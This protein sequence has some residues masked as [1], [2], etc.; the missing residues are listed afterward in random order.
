[1]QLRKYKVVTNLS[2]ERKTPF[3][4]YFFTFVTNETRMIN[5]LS[6]TRMNNPDSLQ[7]MRVTSN[8]AEIFNFNMMKEVF[9]VFV[10]ILLYACD[11]PGR[12]ENTVNGRT[13]LLH[14]IVPFTS[15]SLVN[16]VIEIPAGTNQKWEVNKTTGRI[17]WEQITPDSFRV[18]N[19]LP[20]PANYGF[21]PQTLLPEA[22]GGDGDP[23]DVFVLGSSIAREKI[24][25][26]RIIGIIHMLDDNESDSKL[27]AVNI[28]DS[29]F[30][31]H[32]Y[33]MLIEEYPGVIDI[34]KLWLLNYKG[35][36][37]IN[38]LSV[39]DESEAVR[40]LETAIINYIDQ[41]NK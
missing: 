7:D 13:N 14:D 40:F 25:K 15:D 19:Y 24:V 20:Y 9:T 6:Q 27:L 41:K 12:E 30:D 1:L 16:V 10:L 28:N 5:I 31:V 18:I 3:S 35:P 11:N 39:N 21:V 22:S 8:T 37:K 29:G 23:V 32:S 4:I 36:D 33:E 26:V 38:I 2:A 34:I 17:E